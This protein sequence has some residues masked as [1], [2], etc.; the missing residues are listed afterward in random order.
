MNEYKTVAK[1]NDIIAA[2]QILWLIETKERLYNGRVHILIV[3]ILSLLFLF[4]FPIISYC[5]I[6]GIILIFFIDYLIN[7]IEYFNLSKEQNRA[8]S[9]EYYIGITEENFYH[10]LEKG[11]KKIFI[12]KWSS[13]NYFIDVD[14]KGLLILKDN[15]GGTNLYFKSWMSEKAFNLFK[16]MVYKKIGKKLNNKFI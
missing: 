11:G 12:N 3:I 1:S 6:G 9:Q 4:Y 7:S 8:N 5:L 13:Y 2:G 16:S 15:N 14:K 10:T